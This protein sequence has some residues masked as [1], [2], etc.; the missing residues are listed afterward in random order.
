MRMIEVRK[1]EGESA[2][3]L[4]KRFTKRVKESG[5]LPLVRENRFKNRP[6]SELK[7]KKEALKR[8]ENRKQRE[9]LKKMGKIE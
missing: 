3:N 1:N 8:A 4:I 5:V 6:K 9:H 7:K 2:V